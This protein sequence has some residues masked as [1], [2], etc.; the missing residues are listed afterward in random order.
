MIK[1]LAVLRILVGVLFLYA[2]MTKLLDEE[3]LY[4]GLLER[5]ES[6][7]QAYP[8]YK[9]LLIRY[10]EFRQTRIA[11]LVAGGEIAVGACL[12]SGLFTSIASLGGFFLLVNYALATGAN[13]PARLGAHIAGAL[14]LLVMGRC[15]AGLQWGVDGI[16][17]RRFKDWVVLFPLRVRAPGYAFA[18]SAKAGPAI[19]RGTS[20]AP[21]KSALL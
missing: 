1:V 7:G 11:F 8:F 2:G 12:L 10:V 13:S 16:L 15:C 5:L 17:I 20:R 9:T 4:G 6:Y 21:R 14:L 19:A 18:R 3:L